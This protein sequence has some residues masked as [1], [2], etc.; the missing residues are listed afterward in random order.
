M[1]LVYRYRYLSYSAI[2]WF[3]CDPCYRV[4]YIP[5]YYELEH[6]N[7]NKL[8]VSN[9]FFLTEGSKHIF[10]AAKSN[11]S[12]ISAV[13]A[14]IF[15]FLGVPIFCFLEGGLLFFLQCVCCR[16][17]YPILFITVILNGIWNRLCIAGKRNYRYFYLFLLSLSFHCVFIFTCSLSHLILLSKQVSGQDKASDSARTQSLDQILA[18]GHSVRNQGCESMSVLYESGCKFFNW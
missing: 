3:A 8:S 7:E 16:C 14:A 17:F 18:P 12:F 13:V 11:L 1:V 6:F 4:R 2:K 10:L 15:S 9:N 5:V